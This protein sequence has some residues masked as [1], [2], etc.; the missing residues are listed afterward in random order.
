LVLPLII[1][2]NNKAIWPMGMAALHPGLPSH[3]H[4]LNSIIRN[5]STPLSGNQVRRSKIISSF[6][7]RIS[8]METSNRSR[9][10]L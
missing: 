4:F 9:M 7:N 6:S 1:S 8:R 10:D 5:L 2:T 3:L